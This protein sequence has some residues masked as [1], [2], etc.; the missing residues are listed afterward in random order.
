M[1][2]IIF[3]RAKRLHT[4][5][6]SRDNRIAAILVSCDEFR[7]S[8]RADVDCNVQTFAHFINMKG[9]FPSLRM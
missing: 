7:K 9:L 3:R 5:N 2:F 6:R 8:G 1:A 4:A